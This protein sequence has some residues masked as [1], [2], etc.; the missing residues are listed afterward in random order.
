MGTSFVTTFLW[1]EEGKENHR[2]LTLVPGAT[3][4][5]LFRTR[6]MLVDCVSKTHLLSLVCNVL[7]KHVKVLGKHVN[8]RNNHLKYS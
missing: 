5:L 8:M 3:R 7:R 4:F 2:M 1:S 6:G